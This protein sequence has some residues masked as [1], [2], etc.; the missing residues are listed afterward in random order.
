LLG[1]VGFGQPTL[2]NEQ[3]CEH[4][5]ADREVAD[6][7][8][9][10]LGFPDV[11][12]GELAFTE[13]DARALRL[14]TEGLEHLRPEQREQAIELMLHEAR[15]VSANLANLAEIE[16]EALGALTAQGLRRRLLE[17]AVERGIEDSDFGWLLLYVL[18]RQLAAAL[19]RRAPAE[20]GDGLRR[21]S[22][23]VG[24]V[25]L[26]GFT[27]LSH[28]L[29]P[30]ELGEMLGRFESLAFDVVTEAGGRVVKLIGDEAML[31]C[32]EA[33]AAA[34]A[35]LEILGAASPTGLPSA[36]AGI[37]LGEVLLQG[38][39]YFGAPVN[40]ASRI[41]DRAPEGEVI[42]D[43]HAAEAIRRGPGLALEEFPKTSL[44]GIGAPPLWRV[45][46][47]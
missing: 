4:A 32:P 36:R 42:V 28:Q 26:V 27:S 43:E 22:L 13:E 46:E 25:D 10:A 39:D 11:P 6:R 47:R 29:E 17:Q 23:A 2:D 15:I 14:A 38:G 21:E 30:S 31:V 7:L 45:T 5:N 18:R 41:V 12:E 34:R 8:W 44:K 20:P 37:A 19:R 35:A 3:V 16:T 1:L 33:V 40:L 9:R 24:F